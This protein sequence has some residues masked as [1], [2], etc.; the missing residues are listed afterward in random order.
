MHGLPVV[1]RLLQAFVASLVAYVLRAHGWS[2]SVER[3]GLRV[4]RRVERVTRLHKVGKVLVR[5]VLVVE[6]DVA[7]QVEAADCGWEVAS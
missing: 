5:R 4:V 1:L 7:L 3:I 2:R 6:V